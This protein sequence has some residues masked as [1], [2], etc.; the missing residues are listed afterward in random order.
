M[1][2]FTAAFVARCS[3]STARLGR[4]A[5]LLAVDVREAERLR[6]LNPPIGCQR[7]P[8]EH[9]GKGEGEERK[10]ARAHAHTRWHARARTHARRTKTKGRWKKERWERERRSCV[11][12]ASLKENDSLALFV[13]ALSLLSHKPR[14][15]VAKSRANQ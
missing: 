8:A 15:I 11:R 10:N 3:T 4:A 14:L 1:Y 2:P 12:A 7:S 6:G 5:S 9:G 13:H